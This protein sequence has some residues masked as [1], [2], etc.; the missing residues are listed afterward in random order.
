MRENQ[1]YSS[2]L[3]TLGD[4]TNLKFIIHKS[5]EFYNTEHIQSI[6]R[7]KIESVET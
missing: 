3:D 6:S 5:D 1:L 4:R 7:K 2:E